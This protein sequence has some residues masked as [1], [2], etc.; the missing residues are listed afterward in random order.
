LKRALVAALVV[1]ATA[2]ACTQEPAKPAAP[3]V[4]SS[5]A[6]PQEVSHSACETPFPAAWQ[7]AIEN[8]RVDT[9]GSTTPLA[10]GR[11]GE[12]VA[13]RDNGDTR[14]VLLIGADKSVE[15]IYPVPDPNRND[16]GF[17]AMDDRWIV[18]GVV[19]IP[20]GSN[21]VLPTLTQIDLVDR[22]GG[23][24]RTVVQATD[25]DYR[26][27]GPTID[28]VA[29]FDGKVYWITHEKYASSNGVMRSYDVN[30]G[31]VAEVKSGSMNSVRTRAIGLTEIVGDPSQRPTWAHTEV[32]LPAKLPMP[33]ADAV[34]TGPDRFSLATDG[35]VYAWLTDVDHGAAGLA[36][37]SPQS[38]LVR[39]I[40]DIVE[41]T[42]WLP[43]V[44][45][46]GPYV[47]IGE[48]RKG[49]NASAS[50]V[51]TRSGARTSIDPWVVG[52][53]G[54]TIAIHVQHGPGGKLAPFSPVVLRTDQLPQLSC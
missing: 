27:G 35:T 14:D 32:T 15:E 36:W 44:S 37:W 16:A 22:N 3:P 6:A 10:V 25:E 49:S 38:G 40:G 34:G 48:G 50:V 12:V 31:A 33:V 1:A 53:D 52:A 26:T 9:G 45:V 46:V 51:D 28:S 20:R 11:A 39:V 13:V 42:D 41:V 54:G 30:T 4:A 19:R 21:G 8:N 47:V 24:V 17:A 2:V 29:L 5:S 43:P 18:V 23:S 7:Q